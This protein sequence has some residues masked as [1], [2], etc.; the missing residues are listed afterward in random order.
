M[1]EKTP[2]EVD[3]D[4]LRRIMEE[5]ENILHDEINKYKYD[6]DEW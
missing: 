2:E 4:Q 1:E 6:L 5:N 3:I